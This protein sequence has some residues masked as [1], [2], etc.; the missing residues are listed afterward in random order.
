VLDLQELKIKSE[1]ILVKIDDLL[2]VFFAMKE[3]HSEELESIPSLLL[4]LSQII[5][6]DFQKA[7]NQILYFSN[8][9]EEKKYDELQNDL[10]FFVDS[11]EKSDGIEEEQKDES[12]FTSSNPSVNFSS[13]AL[14]LLDDFLDEAEDQLTTF[15]ISL[16]KYRQ[17]PTLEH[18]TVA[19][20]AIH[21]LKGGFR[22]IE[23]FP[24]EHVCHIC[25]DLL[26]QWR[27]G[28]K[29]V[30]TQ[31]ISILLDMVDQLREG[32]E[33][34][35]LFRSPIVQN[36]DNIIDKIVSDDIEEIQ[37]TIAIF[38]PLQNGPTHLGEIPFSEGITEIRAYA[39]NS[40]W[41]DPS[42]W[43]L[44]EDIAKEFSFHNIHILSTCALQTLLSSNPIPEHDISLKCLRRTILEMLV[45][46]E[47]I[48]KEID[49]REFL[50][51]DS[52]HS[53]VVEH[54]RIPTQKL[55]GIFQNLV[56]FEIIQSRIL[57]HMPDIEQMT[58]TSH[59]KEI[60]RDV[61]RL[62]QQ[63]L[64]VLFQRIPKMA[65]DIAKQLKKDVRVV[66]EG[67]NLSL[68]RKI[69][70][71]LQGPFLHIIRN[72]ID[73][74]IEQPLQRLEKGKPSQAT[75]SVSA[76]QREQNIFF[77]IADDGKGI[78]TSIILQK[79][80]E[81]KMISKND[82]L[83]SK[84]ILDLIFQPGFSTK[85]TQNKIS[86]RGVGLDVV[87]SSITEISGSIEVHTEQGKGTRFEL[88][89]PAR[90]IALPHLKVQNAKQISYLIHTNKIKEIIQL[91]ESSLT[92]NVINYR[93]QSIP[94]I[95]L[96]RVVQ[97]DELDGLESYACIVQLPGYLFALGVH[98][99]FDIEDVVVKRVPL[100]F[101]TYKMYSG[102][103]IDKNKIPSLIINLHYIIKTFDLDQYALQ[104]EPMLQDIKP[105]FVSICRDN[106]WYS[107]PLNALQHHSSNFLQI[108]EALPLTHI[109]K[110]RRNHFLYFHLNQ[111]LHFV[112][113][114]QMGDITEG[115]IHPHIEVLQRQP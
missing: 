16:K 114:D 12:T 51:L 6:S 65:S 19:F 100:F 35:A 82:E 99:V 93:G 2:E 85:E 23:S 28:Q 53:N 91:K 106:K 31:K 79:A 1:E 109:K 25:E 22:F 45:N 76:I 24:E 63:K 49:E 14:M 84:E 67:E 66:I 48:G 4:Q 112:D 75:L 70:E 56:E 86:G 108:S 89:I 92:N 96:D 60:T 43:E 61:E 37:S 73:H 55:D 78:D 20:R 64:N 62:Q 33:H 32:I 36:Y 27:D 95:S 13:N 7:H 54:I 59:I 46:L 26:A 110:N 15:E 102:A 50:Q 69:I 11:L 17:K 74:G 5:P 3:D 81:K 44:I 94:Y 107:L 40:L 8:L 97:K 90:H 80:L 21:T 41:K 71:A 98:S 39:E 113:I 57:H 30:N 72:A 83:S 88:M 10:L 105:L 47:E 29:M 104:E 34:I 58:L 101:E 68:N 38:R 42:V 52:E 18:I 87:H 103:A 115:N 111:K 9:F 77:V